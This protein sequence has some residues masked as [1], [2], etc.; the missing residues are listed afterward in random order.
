MG[1]GRHSDRLWAM[2]V[3]LPGWISRS[4][5]K[6]RQKSGIIESLVNGR[7][8]ANALQFGVSKQPR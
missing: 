4:N 2:R 8:L 1:K 7:L 6:L 3:Q 5:D